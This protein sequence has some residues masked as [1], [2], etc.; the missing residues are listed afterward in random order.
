MARVVPLLSTDAISVHRFD[1]PVE[2]EDQPYSEIANAFMASFVEE[3]R[4]NLEIGERR[5]SVAAGDVML[6][7]PGMAFRAG[8][9]GTGFS[10]RCLSVVY[11]EAKDEDFDRTRSWARAARPVVASSDRVKFLR[12][13][14]LRAIEEGAPMLAEYCASAIFRPHGG[15]DAKPVS[16]RRFPWYAERVHAARERLDK[17]FAAE[18]TIADLARSAGM[19]PFHFARVFAALLGRPP[20]RYLADARMT[21]ASAMLKDG[22]S[23][24]E[25]CFAVGFNNLSHF[26]RCFR[27]R[28]GVSPSAHSGARPI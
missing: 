27:A 21:A 28:Y 15:P 19:S 18:H 16:P 10:D 14:L 23:V 7:H 2:H 8:F 25:T 4:F 1:H 11:R 13:G 3:G 26:S 5:W 9:E 22:R 12:W 24:T 6:S 17:E 20:H